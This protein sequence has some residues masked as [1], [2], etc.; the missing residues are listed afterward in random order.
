MTLDVQ[1]IPHR[2]FKGLLLACLISF[3]AYGMKIT[4]GVPLM[5]SAL[6]MGMVVNPFINSRSDYK[7]GIDFSAS[8]LLKVGIVL[9]GS[10]ISF[11]MISALGWETLTSIIAVVALSVILGFLAGK[12]FKKT[13]QLSLLTATA[14]SICG[15]SAALAIACILPASKSKDQDLGF[16]IMAVTVFSSIG[17]I[18]YPL[19]AH[20]LN[21]SESM[22]GVLM[23]LSL[24]NVAQA[25]A[26]GFLVSETS[27]ETATI[28]KMA[29]I[30][31]LVPYLICM[32]LILNR[33]FENSS[34]C[35]RPAIMPSFLLGFIAIVILNSFHLIPP[36]FQQYMVAGSKTLL[37]ISVAAIGLQTSIGDVK[38][39]GFQAFN[40]VFLQSLIILMLSILV[41]ISFS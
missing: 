35:N 37:C 6:I 19:I 10:R 25:V 2:V 33:K 21:F 16:T 14:V 34:N 5:L 30:S 27:G 29:R 23:G 31:L 9:L 11:E 12:L 39:M 13:T 8:T 40:L 41:V 3:C 20:I 38:K 15:A 36:Y 7:A 28:V 32:N 24:H 22:S 18:A 17:M 26:S 4:M 1:Q